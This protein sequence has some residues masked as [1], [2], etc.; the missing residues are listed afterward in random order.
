MFHLFLNKLELS[1]QKHQ[2]NGTVRDDKYKVNFLFPM[3]EFMSYGIDPQSM[4]YMSTILLKYNIDQ[5]RVPKF[6]LYY[7]RDTTHPSH[8]KLFN[9]CHKVH[10]MLWRNQ[11]L[12][13]QE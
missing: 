12:E 6:Q 5:V 13:L 3:K 1:N 7:I 2:S 8:K 11:E 4:F 9:F 10:Y